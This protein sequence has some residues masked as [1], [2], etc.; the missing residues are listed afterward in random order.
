MKRT[1]NDFSGKNK[2]NRRSF[3]VAIWTAAVCFLAVGGVYYS[4]TQQQ[5]GKEESRTEARQEQPVATSAQNSADNQEWVAD[6]EG[7]SQ[8]SQ[9]ASVIVKPKK[10][11]SAKQNKS[12]E[13]D[14]K[15]NSTD[16]KK[17]ES[18]QTKRPAQTAEQDK[19]ELSFQEDK[20]LSWPVKGDVLMKFS[21]K[22][23]VYFKTLAEYRSN[24]AIEISASA[25]TKVK[26]SAAGRVIDISQK[27]EIGTTVTM[28]IGGSYKVVYGQLKDICVKKGQS[29]AAGDVIGKVAAPTKYFTEEGDNLYFQVTQN[30]KAVDPLLLLQ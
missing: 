29:V 7:N 16:A 19:D 22:N 8:E 23:T 20:G 10:N 27:E 17:K 5:K 6:A 14:S 25:G 18:T 30:D 2:S 28:D 24:P 11:N 9:E 13:K 1:R 26:A 4:T 15:K 12:T 21:D 3:Y